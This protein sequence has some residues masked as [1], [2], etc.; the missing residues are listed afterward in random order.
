MKLLYPDAAR[1]KQS[2][3]RSLQMTAQAYVNERQ[4][5]ATFLSQPAGPVVP[6]PALGGRKV[7]LDILICVEGAFVLQE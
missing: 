3:A 4:P 6:G 2:A 5:A 1:V 7:A